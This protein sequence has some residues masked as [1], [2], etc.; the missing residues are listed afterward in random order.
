MTLIG[1]A[2]RILGKWAGTAAGIAFVYLF[3]VDCDAS[4]VVC[5]RICYA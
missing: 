3:F 2:R 5:Q 1:A 4:A